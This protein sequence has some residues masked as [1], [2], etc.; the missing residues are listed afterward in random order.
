MNNINYLLDKGI[1]I[2][3][4]EKEKYYELKENINEY[5]EF[6][7]KE[8]GWKVIVN[9]KI[10]K[11]EKKPYSK[12]KYSAISEFNTK[13]EF[14][15]FTSLLIVL[16][17]M[18]DSEQFILSELISLIKDELKS[19]F[20]L[21]LNQYHYIKK[22]INVLKYAE[23]NYL[24]S[25]IDGKIDNFSDDTEVEVLYQNTGISRYYSL[26]DFS[27]NDDYSDDNN[28]GIDVNYDLENDEIDIDKGKIRR[29]RVYTRLLTESII[30][31]ATGEDLDLAYIKNQRN[32]INDNI[33]KYLDMELEVY[34]N[35]A[36]LVTDSKDRFGQIFPDDKAITGICLRLLSLLR[37][38]VDEGLIKT[39]LSMYTY[40][41]KEL[42]QLL[43][44]EKS[45]NSQAWGKQLREMKIDKLF[46][47]ILD[48]LEKFSFIKIDEDNITFLPSAGK[49]TG[50][51]PNDYKGN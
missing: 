18:E 47:E 42:L 1:I 24:I 7:E 27:L 38:K 37:K 11:L 41:R 14:M 25:V 16:G 34:Q 29:N 3:E 51:Y 22:L 40:T 49:F 15:I 46:I 28:K 20:I 8:L 48:N 33:M 30:Y 2:R 45:T 9:E 35:C 4:F 13:E 5:T 10:I 44:E 31:S 36:F 26:S 39:N 43:E 21:D 6:F 19:F 50:T 23:N 12:N 17:S 32:R